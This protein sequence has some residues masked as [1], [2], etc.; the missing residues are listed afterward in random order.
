MVSLYFSV[1]LS[2]L[3]GIKLPINAE[4]I[5]QGITLKGKHSISRSETAKGFFIITPSSPAVIT[6]IQKAEFSP[7]RIAT[8]HPTLTPLK[9]TGK[10]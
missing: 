3:V 5:S 9:I 7:V 10:K 4:L 1:E 6:P 2:H 8:P